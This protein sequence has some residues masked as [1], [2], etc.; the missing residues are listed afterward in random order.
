MRKAPDSEREWHTEP[1]TL[2]WAIHQEYG[3]KMR[4]REYAVKNE[5]EVRVD[6]LD[7]LSEVLDAAGAVK[8]SDT[9]S[10]SPNQIEFRSFVTLT[11]AIR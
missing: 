3:A 8:T 9:L 6:N 11:A 4:V 1:I 2:I 7:L 10:I 5:I